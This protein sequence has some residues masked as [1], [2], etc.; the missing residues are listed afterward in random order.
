MKLNKV[1][2]GYDTLKSRNGI[3][4]QFSPI[5]RGLV[6]FWKLID[7]DFVQNF[8]QKVRNL[9]VFLSEIYCPKIWGPKFIVF[10]VYGNECLMKSVVFSLLL[11]IDWFQPWNSL[12]PCWFG[13]WIPGPPFRASWWI[14]IFVLGGRVKNRVSFSGLLAKTV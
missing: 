10:D 4:F 9:G 11:L 6:R 5:L 13:A 14:N 1:V 7:N 2:K 3:F 8:C 12:G